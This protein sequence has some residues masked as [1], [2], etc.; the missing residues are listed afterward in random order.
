MGMGRGEIKEKKRKD[1]N[2]RG[3]RDE[4]YPYR[5]VPVIAP[6]DLGGYVVVYDILFFSFSFRFYY[7]CTIIIIIIISDGDQLRRWTRASWMSTRISE[8]V[9]RIGDIVQ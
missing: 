1:E 7:Y 2:E 6:L 8:Y 5:I 3:E 9:I 4:S